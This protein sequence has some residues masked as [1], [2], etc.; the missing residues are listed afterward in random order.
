MLESKLYRD[1]HTCMK[2]LL[3]KLQ[4]EPV[5]ETNEGCVEERKQVC[6]GE[7]HT[8]R[9]REAVGRGLKRSGI[10]VRGEEAP[11]EARL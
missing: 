4:L 5:K 3:C 8:M 7:N 10:V 1:N 9:H 11:S 2:K 6:A